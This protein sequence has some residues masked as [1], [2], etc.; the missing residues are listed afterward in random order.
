MFFVLRVFAALHE[1]VIQGLIVSRGVVTMPT[2]GINDSDRGEIVIY[3]PP[4][5]AATLDVR[6]SG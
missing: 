2:N 3:Q 1:F 6:L 4:S 5:G